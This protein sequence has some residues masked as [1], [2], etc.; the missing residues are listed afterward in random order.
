MLASTLP[1][2][3]V[4]APYLL[5]GLWVFYHSTPVRYLMSAAGLL[6]VGT[7]GYFI[8]ANIS[9]FV[10]FFWTTRSVMS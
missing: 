7:T 2:L 8:A 3:L 6:L 4:L 1:M 10:A 9:V 5:A